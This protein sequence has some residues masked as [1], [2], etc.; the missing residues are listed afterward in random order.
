[1]PNES[2]DSSRIVTL[3]R[4][5]LTES[6]RSD[7]KHLLVLSAIGFA[8]VWG[9]LI[10]TDFS[11]LG[12]TAHNIDANGLSIT[13]A[14]VIGYLSLPFLFGAL[15]DWRTWK[16]QYKE[17]QFES[18]AAVLRAVPSPNARQQT[19]YTARQAI[20]DN[21]VALG[22]AFFDLGL[23][24]CAAVAVCVWLLSWDP[25]DRA[26]IIAIVPAE[27][28]G[29]Q[30]GLL[31][32]SS[33]ALTWGDDRSLATFVIPYEHE[34]VCN[35]LNGSAP[36]MSWTGVDP[37]DPQLNFVSKLVSDLSECATTQKSVSLEL[38]GFASSSSLQSLDDCDGV[39]DMN[40]I[41]LRVANFRASR[42][43]ELLDGEKRGN[44]EI[45]AKKWDTFPAMRSERLFLDRL[46]SGDYSKPRGK[47]TRR[48]EL[49]LLKAGD[50]EIIRPAANGER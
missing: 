20:L 50:C 19:Q 29:S 25:P 49:R 37:D 31:L 7:R 33:A 15:A 13:L 39:T 28:T 47:L 6:T 5:P 40:E 45:V 35:G 2:P 14:V 16:W 27:T 17:E 3:L 30:K 1:M 10:P 23:P 32:K 38:W 44:V 4:G 41:N 26:Q 46:F 43:K 18:L 22:K 42:L 36:K 11:L 24:V 8:V 12:L 34:A 48:V 21:I 9:N